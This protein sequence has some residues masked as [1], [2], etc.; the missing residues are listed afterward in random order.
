M[1]DETTTITDQARDTFV[2][3]FGEEQAQAIEAAARQH[4][5]SDGGFGGTHAD[6]NFGSQ[7]FR[8]WFLKAIGYECV[9]RDDFRAEHGITADVVAMQCWAQSP[10]EGNLVEHDGDVPDYLAVMAG[11]YRDWIPE[12]DTASQRPGEHEEFDAQGLP[13]E[14][15]GAA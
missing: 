4:F 13:V 11:A 12:G 14:D 6:D 5:D 9:T 8:Y 1:N 10:F 15:G 3:R 2:A 7:P